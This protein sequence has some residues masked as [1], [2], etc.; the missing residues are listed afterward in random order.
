MSNAATAT[1]IGAP[2]ERGG[3]FGGCV[4]AGVCDCAF[5]EDFLPMKKFTR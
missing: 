3:S 4:D 5:A 2:N 1:T